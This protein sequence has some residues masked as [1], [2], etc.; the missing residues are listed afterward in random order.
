MLSL[1]KP[2]TGQMLISGKP[3]AKEFFQENEWR[4]VPPGQHMMDEP[5]FAD[6]QAMAIMN[7]Y[8]QQAAVKVSP[9][10][11]KYIFVKSDSEIPDLVDFI[12]TQLG[13]FPHND[14]KLLTTRILS[15]DTIS[16]DL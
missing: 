13:H 8:M 9:G 16:A 2:V 4:F 11:I 1:T 12:N 10:D 7:D 5:L 14:I 15:L 6:K 3:V